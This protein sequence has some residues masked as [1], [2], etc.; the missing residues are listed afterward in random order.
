MSVGNTYSNYPREA[1]IT[2]IC[3][4]C[5]TV[6][7]AVIP[8]IVSMWI[9]F[10]HIAL[11]APNECWKPVLYRPS[12]TQIVSSIFVTILWPIFDHF[13]CLLRAFINFMIDLLLKPQDMHKAVF[14]TIFI[15]FRSFCLFL[16]I[17]AHTY[18]SYIARI[19]FL[20]FCDHSGINTKWHK[21]NLNESHAIGTN[22]AWSKSIPNQSNNYDTNI[23]KNIPTKTCKT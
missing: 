9:Y 12:D 23:I 18:R 4:W 11:R 6:Q 1:E 21:W 2:V 20:D 10:A 22:C 8:L 16:I 3:Q 7:I 13:W 19:T 14:C 5:L 15:K 17:I